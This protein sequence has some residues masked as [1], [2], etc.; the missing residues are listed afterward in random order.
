MDAN[1]RG[2]DPVVVMPG[3]LRFLTQ[4]LMI[5]HNCRVPVVA[6]EEIDHDITSDVVGMVGVQQENAAVTSPIRLKLNTVATCTR[7]NRHMVDSVNNSTYPDFL[8]HDMSKTG[9][10]QND[11]TKRLVDEYKNADR[12]FESID[13]AKNPSKYTAEQKLIMF[14]DLLQSK[15]NYN[16]YTDAVGQYYSWYGADAN[17]TAGVMLRT[18]KEIKADYD[19]AISSLEADTDVQALLNKRLF[20]EIREMFA[21]GKNPGPMPPSRIISRRMSS[22]EKC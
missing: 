20:Q 5:R 17:T 19:R 21:E 13:V 15:A 8:Q 14:L 3:E 4:A 9:E 22:A 12:S 7:G 11:A 18:H 10:L 16:G 2:F 1:E 6:I